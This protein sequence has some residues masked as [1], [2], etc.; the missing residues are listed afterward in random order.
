MSSADSS[1]DA[2]LLSGN[3]QHRDDEER[4]AVN[5]GLLWRLYIS[6]LLSTW[7]M[8]SYEFTVILLFAKAFPGTLLPTSLRG[9]L[10]NGATLLFSP[11]IGRWVDRNAS[12]FHTIK[13]TIVV[14]RAAI[15]L[16]CLLWLV[17]FAASAGESKRQRLLTPPLLLQQQQQ[18][19]Q[20]YRKDMVILAILMVLGIIE[21]TCAVGNTLVMERDWVPTIACE[22]TSTQAAVSSGSLTMTATRSA[23]SRG[24]AAEGSV[25][26]LHALNATMRRIDLISKILAP[27][28]VSALAIRRGEQY[29]AGVTAA[30]NLATVGIELVTAKSAW[31][32]CN[33]LKMER[34]GRGKGPEEDEEREGLMLYFSSDVCLA[35]LSTALQSFSVL[36]LSGPMT[37]YLLTRNY[38]LS[39][40]TTARTAISAIEIGSTLIFP[41]ATSFL[42]PRVRSPMAVLGL[43]GV[44]LQLALLIPCFIA[45]VSV[46]TADNA[47]LDP[48][49]AFPGYTVLI[50]VFLGLSRLGHWTHNMAVQ[51]IAQ[52]HVSAQQRVEFSGVE[53]TFVSAAE[54]LRWASAAVWNRPSEFKGVAAGGL[55]SVVV[56]WGLF[57]A[58]VVL[59][60]KKTRSN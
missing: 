7:N 20:E 18:Q 3:S 22:T 8:R 33:V 21:R 13:V 55:G 24:G 42:I 28:F 6:H 60:N 53:M 46:P 1:E 2:P 35:S 51:Q 41:L 19:Q 37:T 23:S 29:L 10:T 36:S 11:H 9:V 54:I 50:F 31:E 44:T 30:M 16:G 47:P 52:T 25:P 56:I 5:Q 39:L 38:S 12:R 34:R 48:A 27:V 32:S 59:Q 15:V 14:Q 17:L 26:A 58:F 4:I 43:S 40:I 57:A 45:L 49:A